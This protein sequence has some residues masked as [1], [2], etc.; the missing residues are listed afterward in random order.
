MTSFDVI[1]LLIIGWAAVAGVLRGFVCEVLSLIAW[2][3][4]VAA[5]RLFHAPATALAAKW[6]GT[7]T[8]GAILAFVLLFAVTF[9]G[10][11]LV[12]R[13]LGARTRSS[14]VGPLDRA[15]GLGFGALKGLIVAS[16]IF[17]GVN[18]FFDMVWGAAAPKP[19]WVAASRTTPLLRLSSAAISDFVE[20]RRHAGATP[21]DQPG[22]GEKARDALGDLV[23]KSVPSR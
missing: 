3:A 18:L 17:L 14:A 4:A 2:V 5:L 19:A 10:F 15:L 13:Q 11:R 22:Y 21:S 6:T 1:V 8:G 20:K 16:L 9:F 12:A 23:E 7:E